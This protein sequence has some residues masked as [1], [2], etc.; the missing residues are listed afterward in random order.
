M[1]KLKNAVLIFVLT[2]SLLNK[3]NNAQIRYS[4]A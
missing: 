4:F 1:L 3:I 2:I